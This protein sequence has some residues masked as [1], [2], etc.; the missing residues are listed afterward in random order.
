MDER[1]M[2][3]ISMS[4]LLESIEECFIDENEEAYCEEGKID[5]PYWM[6]VLNQDLHKYSCLVDYI[7]DDYF[8]VNFERT[9]CYSEFG[10]I[11]IHKMSDDNDEDC[12]VTFKIK[13]M[14][15]P[16]HWGYCQCSTEDKGYDTR[17]KCCGNG[18]D[19]DAPSFEVYKEEYIGRSSFSGIEHDIWDLEDEYYN[20]TLEKK[21]ELEIKSELDSLKRDRESIDKRI[22][23]L[24]K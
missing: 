7:G 19:W 22:A 2:K 11:D 3:D 16:R 18:C 24:T 15:E 14:F 20:I 10:V 23:E 4:V 6:S 9:D 21:R 1:D 12:N 5:I 8:N 13:L 17:H